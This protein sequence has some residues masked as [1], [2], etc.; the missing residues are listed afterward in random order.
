MRTEEEIKEKIQ[1]IL[2]DERLSYPT[3]VVFSNAPLALIQHAMVTELH[4]L[5]WV[6]GEPLTEI[7]KLRGE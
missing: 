7:K 6:I 1:R 2:S 5:Q 4:T 3:A